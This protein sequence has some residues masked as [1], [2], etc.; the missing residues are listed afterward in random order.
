MHPSQV[1][2]EKPM[3][4]LQNLRRFKHWVAQWPFYRIRYLRD[5]V[6][7]RDVVG[8]WLGGNFSSCFAGIPSRWCNSFL[9]MKIRGFKGVKFCW[10]KNVLAATVFFSR[11]E[12]LLRCS[13]KPWD[14]VEC[15][16]WERKNDTSWLQNTASIVLGWKTEN[17]R[18][19]TDG[20]LSTNIIA[21]V[22]LKIID[23]QTRW[24]D[25]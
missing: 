17:L 19:V 2:L 7:F 10:V 25:Y 23:A 15:L 5:V 16:L 13:L 22:W 12:M 20:L 6:M 24:L 4:F 8:G 18:V 11:T 21:W 14:R 1:Q 3:F 9:P